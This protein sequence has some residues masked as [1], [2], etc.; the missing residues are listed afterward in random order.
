MQARRTFE[1]AATR[2][3]PFLELSCKCIHNCRY[4]RTRP[5]TAPPKTS[6]NN[7]CPYHES[8]LRNLPKFATSPPKSLE[9][10]SVCDER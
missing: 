8:S 2:P 7:I 5:S 9:E 1:K 10:P 4:L 3:N 6:D